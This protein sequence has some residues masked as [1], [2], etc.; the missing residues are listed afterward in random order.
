MEKIVKNCKDCVFNTTDRDDTPYCKLD[1]DNRDL[2]TTDPNGYYVGDEIPKWC[3]IMSDGILI[4]LK[5]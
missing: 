4:K 1:E 3:P 2:I 5:Q